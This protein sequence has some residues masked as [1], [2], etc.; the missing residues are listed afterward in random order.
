MN[1]EMLMDIA[2]NPHNGL[3]MK[4]NRYDKTSKKLKK[5]PVVSF[6]KNKG[7]YIV[8]EEPDA[9]GKILVHRFRADRKMTESMTL[10]DSE[11]KRKDASR[12]IWHGFAGTTENLYV[13]C[14]KFDSPKVYAPESKSLKK[15]T[16]PTVASMIMNPGFIKA[17]AAEIIRQQKK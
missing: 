8:L 4:D 6:G 3:R 13:W 10:Q 12:A 16:T 2:T 11:P 17:L 5:F 7:K 1:N 15:A 14:K 9:N